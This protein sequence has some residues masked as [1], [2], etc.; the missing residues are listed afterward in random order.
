MY[1]IILIFII[2]YPIP[3]MAIDQLVT[4]AKSTALAGAVTANPPEIMAI[5]HNPAGLSKSREG[6]MYQQ[7][8]T[9]LGFNRRNHFSPDKSSS[10]VNSFDPSEDPVSNKS[11]GRGKSFLYYPIYGDMS[12][13][14]FTLPLPLGISYRPQNSRWVMAFGAY[15]PFS[16]GN[17][18]TSD[19]PS[20]YQ[21]SAYYQQHLVFASPSISYQWNDVF[22][23]GFSIGLGQTALGQDS[24]LRIPNDILP[25]SKI[26]TVNGEIGT[27][28]S[29]ANIQMEM[30]DDTAFSFNAGALWSPFPSLKFGCV[31]RSPINSHPKGTFDIQYSEELLKL[32]KWYRENPTISNEL[33]KAPGLGKI[34]NKNESSSI[35]LDSFQWPDTI[36]MGIYY[37]AK[38]NLRLM[39]DLQWTRWSGQKENRLVFSKSDIQLMSLLKAL[40]QE[41]VNNQTLLYQKEKK[42]TWTYHFGLEWQI[43]ESLAIRSGFFRRPQSI[44]DSHMDLMSMP[45]LTYI[46]AGVEWRW[47]NRWV[48]EQGFGYFISKNKVIQSNGSTQL[49]NTD[50]NNAFFSPYA[51]QKVSTKVSG[52]VISMNI[53]IPLSK[54]VYK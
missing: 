38:F 17:S 52:F 47:P 49:N 37:K 31:Y 9:G 48:I 6:I 21:S 44:E 25:L 28:D 13:D 46:G 20:Q 41:S 35:K 50:M 14:I 2:L 54:T 40:G 51:G 8:L 39:F 43:K 32:S 3:T 29:L 7:G 22:S 4:G 19:D 15:M 11:S 12:G 1:Q 26:P 5:H 18:Y 30:R 24:N 53:H 27:F 16:W 10:S 45:D 34:Y 36:Q 33:L 23:V 42:D